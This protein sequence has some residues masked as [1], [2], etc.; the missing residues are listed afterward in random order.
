MSAG[1]KGGTIAQGRPGLLP[2]ASHPFAGKDQATD[3]VNRLG[4][5]GRN[6]LLT[7][8][9]HRGCCRHAQNNAGSVKIWVRAASPQPPAVPST[10]SLPALFSRTRWPSPWSARMQVPGTR[11]LAASNRDLHCWRGIVE[12]GRGGGFV[13]AGKGRRELGRSGALT[14]TARPLRLPQGT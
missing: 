14:F 8:P 1:S 5:E 11:T 13:R 9:R 4:R 10:P 6:S 7:R 2:I 12:G 3:C